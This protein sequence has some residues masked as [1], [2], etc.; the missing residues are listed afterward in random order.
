MT[1]LRAFVTLAEQLHFGRTADRLHITQPALT[2][3]IQ[4]LEDVVGGALVR[5]GYREVQLTEAGQVLL[6]RAERLLEESAAVLDTARRAVRGQLGVLRIGFGLATIQL[7]PEPAAAVPCRA[8]GGRAPAARHGDA[9][10][11]GGAG[12]R[13]PR[14][15]LRAAPGDRSAHR[16]AADP[17]R[18]PRRAARHAQPLA[19]TRRAAIGVG[20]SRSSRSRAPPRPASPIT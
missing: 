20:S 6:P 9:G 18:A 5:R 4:R 14:C 7:L 2:K 8:A 3:Q 12:A 10:A 16:H 13:R 19:V 1:E 11:G 17:A 15:R